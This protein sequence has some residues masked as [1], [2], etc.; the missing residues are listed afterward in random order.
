MFKE[1]SLH[2]DHQKQFLI[3]IPQC[4]HV[5][6]SFLNWKPNNDK[7][8]KYQRFNS[9][10]V[11]SMILI[12][13]VR[14]MLTYCKIFNDNKAHKSIADKG[15]TAISNL[16]VASFEQMNISRHRTVQKQK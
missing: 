5:F 11:N 10:S 9:H 12:A 4:K 15:C 13:I 3:S 1:K 2:E 6:I 7:L 8:H 14:K 16:L